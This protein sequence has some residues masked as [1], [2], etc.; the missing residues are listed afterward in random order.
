VRQVGYLPELYEDA[1]S[2]KYIKN[3][4]MHLL[5]K[6]KALVSIHRHETNSRPSISVGFESHATDNRIKYN[7]KLRIYLYK[8]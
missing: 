6:K 3:I 4:P 1:R 7:F 2:E 5:T 8:L